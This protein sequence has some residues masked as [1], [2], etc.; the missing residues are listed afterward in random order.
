MLLDSHHSVVNLVSLF[1]VVVI[2][3]ARLQ[4]EMVHSLYTRKRVELNEF[5]CKYDFVHYI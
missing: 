1:L 5:D 2:F 3:L 4:N